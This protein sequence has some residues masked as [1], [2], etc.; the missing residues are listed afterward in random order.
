M[1][2]E[3]IQVCQYIQVQVKRTMMLKVWLL[4]LLPWTPHTM[5]KIRCFQ[6][7]CSTKQLC[8]GSRSICRAEYEL[9][10]VGTCLDDKILWMKVTA[11]FN[12]YNSMSIL[13]V[14]AIKYMEYRILGHQHLIYLKPLQ[15]FL[16]VQPSKISIQINCCHF[17]LQYI[18]SNLRG[19]AHCIGIHHV[20]HSKACM[21]VYE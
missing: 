9:V 12:I 6:G 15:P 11:I 16:L 13:N 20:E 1:C 8:E 7:E 19:N 10:W 2:S 18:H 14:N 17:T 4:L 3:G 5:V 21:N